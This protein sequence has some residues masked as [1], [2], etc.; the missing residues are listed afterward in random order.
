[1]SRALRKLPPLLLATL[2]C[3]AGLAACGNTGSSPSS[4]PAASP[5]NIPTTTT[6]SASVTPT[7]AASRGAASF[8]VPHGDNSI[9][10]YGHETQ[11]AARR[12]ASSALAGFLRARE[13]NKWATACTYLAIPV[14]EQLERLASSTTIK[15]CAAILTKLAAADPTK[16]KANTLLAAVAALRTHANNGFILFYD[17]KTTKYVMPMSLENGAW[18]MTQITPIHYPPSQ[19]VN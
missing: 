3:A 13:N 19:T 14:R 17:P 8:R 5:N 10:D 6:T 9:P 1:M 7:V 4:R 18:K 12:R 2:V 16:I 11:G 15:S